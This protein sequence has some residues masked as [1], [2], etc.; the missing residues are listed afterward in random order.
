MARDP[1]RPTPKERN[2]VLY[3]AGQ[4]EGLKWELNELVKK[5]DPLKVAMILPVRDEAY[6]RFLG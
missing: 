3:R 6:A 5:V 4:T 2:D 1:A